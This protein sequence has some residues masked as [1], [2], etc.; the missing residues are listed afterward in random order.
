MKVRPYRPG[1]RKRGIGIALLLSF[2]LAAALGLLWGESRLPSLEGDISVLSLEDDGTVLC[3]VSRERDSLL[4]QLDTDGT[5]RNHCR[6]DVDQSFQKWKVDGQTVYALMA[7]YHGSGMVQSLVSLSLEEDVMVPRVLVELPEA[8]PDGG[9]IVWQDLTLIDDGRVLLA[10]TSGRGEGYLLFWNPEDG[11]SRLETVLEGESI[12][13][14]SLYSRER[15]LWVD[16]DRRVNL[17]R[18]GLITRDLLRGIMETPQQ[19]QVCGDSWFLSDSVTGDI[20]RVGPDGSVE[21]LWEEADGLRYSAYAVC[22]DNDGGLHVAGACSRTRG[23]E[24]VGE[25]WRISAI[26]CGSRY[27]PLSA[28][29]GWPVA[30]GIFLLLA[31]AEGW[32][33][34][35]LCAHRLSTRITLCQLLAAA[36]LL[37]AVTAI[38]YR[39]YQNT[40]LEEARQTLKLLGDSLA[41][42]LETNTPMNDQTL[43]ETVERLRTQVSFALTEGE[44][45]YTLQVLWQTQNGPAIGYDEAVPSGYLLEDVETRGYLSVVKQIL[46][47]GG[48]TTRMVRGGR[49]ASYLYVRT[50]RQGDSVG[51]V[52]V[53]QSREVLVEGQT[54]FF[55]R[56]LPILAACPLLFLALLWVTRRLLA[57]LD[58]IRGALEEFY[59]CGGGNQMELSGMPKTEL[60]EV[61]R[62]FNQLSMEM[63]IQFNALQTIN[64]AYRRLVPNSLLA[65]MGKENV[66]QLEAGGVAEV[67]GVLLVLVPE[68]PSPGTE[69]PVELLNRESEQVGVFGGVVV[70]HDER[71]LSITALFQEEAKALDCARQCVEQLPV[72]AAVLE[73]DVKMGTFG[74]AHLL[75]PV[76]LTPHMARRL[77][78]LELLRRFGARLIRCGGDPA[79]LRLL[80]WDDGLAFYEETV[81]RESGWRA[82]WQE[83]DALWT[84]ALELYWR[85]EFAPAMRRFAEVLRIVPGD[86]AARWYLFRCE[87]LR[88]GKTGAE[89]IEL[90][91]GWRDGQ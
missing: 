25:G 77:S 89:S 11:S 31:L 85:R 55:Q 82:A 45:S 40:L 37:V 73:A 83:A 49:S 64:D 46:Q 86:T 13:F 52:A 90:L 3:A 81:W 54:Q 9:D 41:G 50:F 53:S 1:V 70:D 79:G 7:T 15:L 91:Y 17:C 61:G 26:D 29:Y 59:L 10:G 27:L 2:I 44:Q 87:T 68:A 33:A 66:S 51:C 6:V 20:C 32:M 58:T 42:D 72:M 21:R 8:S 30:L 5:L 65:L 24:L 39:S 76:A 60:Y 88:D 67:K 71:L 28:R 4:I 12:L 69:Q 75:V 14:L 38:Q 80:G 57:P 56:L 84:Q 19:L 36:L 74:G 16:G 48:E 18:N 62:V 22:R 78:M 34:G 47:E 35:I 63:K 23:A 43:S